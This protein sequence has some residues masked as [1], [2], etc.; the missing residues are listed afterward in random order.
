MWTVDYV[1]TPWPAERRWLDSCPRNPVV[2]H[3]A[4]CEQNSYFLCLEKSREWGNAAPPG[5]LRSRSCPAVP[6][7]S[8]FPQRR[9]ADQMRESLPV[10]HPP[11]RLVGCPKGTPWTWFSALGSTR[12]S[13]AVAAKPLSSQ[14]RTGVNCP[15]SLTVAVSKLQPLSL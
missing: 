12:A 9:V 7:S 8:A 13:S 10:F 2:P 1:K 15:I 4:S 6:A 5:G 11:V 3:A 14:G